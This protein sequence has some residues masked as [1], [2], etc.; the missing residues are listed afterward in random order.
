MAERMLPFRDLLK[1]GTAFQWH[2][3]FQTLFGESKAQIVKEIEGIRIFDPDRPTCLTID[4]SKSGIGF[5]LL[6]KHCTCDKT[7]PFCCPSGWKI[8]FV[9][10]RF[11]HPAESRYAP[12]EGETLAVADSLD[13]ARY[14]ALGCKDLT[15]AVDRKLLLKIFSDRSLEDISNNHLK[16]SRRKHSD[17]DSVWSTS[18]VSNIVLQTVFHAILLVMRR[19]SSYLMMLRK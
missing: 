17:T 14:F 9:G 8:T 15:I 18:L 1:P 19:N 13:K 7:E 6:Q 16:T 4:W 11:T 2:Q 5:W 3:H 12:I 10:S